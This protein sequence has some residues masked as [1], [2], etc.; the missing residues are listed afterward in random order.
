MLINYYAIIF[1]GN[2]SVSV[3]QTQIATLFEQYSM[4]CNTSLTGVDIELTNSEDV[5]V[6]HFMG[7]VT[8]AAEGR[9]RCLITDSIEEDDVVDIIFDLIV[10]CKYYNNTQISLI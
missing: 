10:V 8:F 9:Y 1:S 3:A 5:P 7:N 2:S 4:K 6:P